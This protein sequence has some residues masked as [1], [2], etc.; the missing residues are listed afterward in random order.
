MKIIVISNFK[1]VGTQKGI[2]W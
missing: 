1:S 2:F